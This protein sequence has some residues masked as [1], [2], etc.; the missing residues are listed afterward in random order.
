MNKIVFSTNFQIMIKKLLLL[1]LS[2]IVLSGCSYP[3]SMEAGRACDKWEEEQ[4]ED[5]KEEGKSSGFVRCVLDERSRK[6]LG[7]KYSAHKNH[8]GP[9]YRNFKVIK[10]YKY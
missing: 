6:F 7:Y 3:S 9:D 4:K 5:L 1:P 10:R 8:D 2:L